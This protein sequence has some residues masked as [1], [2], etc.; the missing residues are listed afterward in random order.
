[1]STT[2]TTG[3]IVKE[4]A[5]LRDP[6]LEQEPTD[7]VAMA[8]T[9]TTGHANF[10]SNTVVSDEGGVKTHAPTPPPPPVSPHL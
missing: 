9:R 1:M 4:N 8:S 7:T 5:R 6:R 10:G 2:E 3:C